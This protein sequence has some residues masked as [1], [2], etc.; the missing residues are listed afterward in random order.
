MKKVVRIVI[1]EDHQPAVDGYHYRLSQHKEFEIVAVA[2]YGEELIPILQQHPAD[3][4]LLDIGVPISEENRDPFPTLSLI[5]ELRERYPEL[6][7]IVISMHGE[8]TLIEAALKAGVNGY[9]LKDDRIAI[10]NLGGTIHTVLQGGSYLSQYT[11]EKL[12]GAKVPPVSLSARQL[13]ILSM[14]A[15][16]PNLTK[17]EIAKSLNIADSTVRNLLT[18]VYQRLGVRNLTAAIAAAR[19]LGILTSQPPLY[20]YPSDEFDLVDSLP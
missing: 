19:A 15:A 9:L 1:L 5:V 7:I 3:V 12:S 13:Q 20:P 6:K 17:A 2:T 4:L 10:Q 8:R 16:N 18:S 11:L 14:C